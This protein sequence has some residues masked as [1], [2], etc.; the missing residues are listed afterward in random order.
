MFTTVRRLSRQS[1]R[2]QE[3]GRYVPMEN[4]LQLFGRPLPTC[5]RCETEAPY[6][7]AYSWDERIMCNKCGTIYVITAIRSE[8]DTKTRA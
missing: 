5:P 7:S 4:Y 8:F 2:I 3:R 1:A 6:A